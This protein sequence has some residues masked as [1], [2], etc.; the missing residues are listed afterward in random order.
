[1]ETLIKVGGY[2][3][4]ILVIFHLLFWHIF[5][6]NKELRSLSP[7]NR[8]IMPVINLSLTF[9]FVIFAYLSLRHTEEI[10]NSP[11]GNS[12]LLFMALFWLARSL[13]QITF[14]KLRHWLS[15]VFLGYFLIGTLLYGIPVASQLWRS[16]HDIAV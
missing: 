5:D 11:L 12:L 16:I 7:V 10:L 15:F 6:W 9:V 3:N 14:F 13:M 2:Y 8:S 4:I 1:M